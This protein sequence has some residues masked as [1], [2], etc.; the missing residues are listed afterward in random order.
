MKKAETKTKTQFNKTN[1]YTKTYSSS[2][3]LALRCHM[4]VNR[5]CV[6]PCA[7]L[8][9]GFWPYSST[10]QVCAVSCGPHNKSDRSIWM[11]I[12][13]YGSF[14]CSALSA[15]CQLN[16]RHDVYIYSKWYFFPYFVLS[17]F[18]GGRRVVLL[19]CFSLIQLN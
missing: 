3:A 9:S 18:D 1:T 7:R 11:N 16:F 15:C 5:S 17:N 14:V 10:D 13:K 8:F 19:F 12:N 6:S 4:H 2:I